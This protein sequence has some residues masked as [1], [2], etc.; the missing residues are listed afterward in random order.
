MTVCHLYIAL[1]TVVNAVATL[2]GFQINIRHFGIVA[3][4]FPIDITLIVTQIDTM[5]MTTSVFAA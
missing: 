4:R 2:G 5:H 3:Y 1:V